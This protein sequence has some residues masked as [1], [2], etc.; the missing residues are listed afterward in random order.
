MVRCTAT[1]VLW[2]ADTLPVA[3]ISVRAI[4]AARKAMGVANV[5]PVTGR[6][7]LSIRFNQPEPWP[8]SIGD[9]VRSTARA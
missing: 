8:S 9:S 6:E 2:E 5:I 7:H 1:N 3:S 4:E